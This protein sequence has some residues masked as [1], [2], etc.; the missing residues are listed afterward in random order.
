MRILGIS[1]GEVAGACLVRDGA[2]VSAVSEERF[3]R[4]KNLSCWPEQ[5]ISFVLG[6]DGAGLDS[7]DLIA[8]GYGGGFDRDKHLVLY[9]ERFIEESHSSPQRLHTLFERLGA[10]M[11][12]DERRISEFERW[13]A[14]EG[15]RDRTI[16]IDHHEAHGIGAFECSGFDDALVVTCDGRGDYQS[17]TVSVVCE[18]GETVLQRETSADSLGFYYGRITGLLGFRP[19]DQEGK[20]TGLAAYGDPTRA[21]DLVTRMV[22]LNDGRVRGQF[23][24]FFQPYYHGYSDNL[25]R[26]ASNFAPEDLAAAAQVHLENILGSIVERW[27]HRSR[28]GYLCLAGGVFANVKLNQRLAALPGVNATYVLPPMGDVGLPLQA[29]A[30]AARRTRLPR[31][32]LENVFLGPDASSD[33]DELLKACV[34]A[35]YIVVCESL[36][37]RLVRL[38]E[39]GGVVG[40]YRGRMEFGPRALC[41]RSVICRSSDKSLTARLNERLER[42]DFMPFGPIVAEELASMA[43]LGWSPDDLPSRFMTMTYECSDTFKHASPSVVHVDGT[44]RPQVITDRGDPFIHRLLLM[45]HEATGELGLVN[46]S[47][48]V[49][50]EPIVC[51]WKDAFQGLATSRIDALLVGNDALVI[52]DGIPRVGGY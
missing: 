22:R 36:H 47:F 13:I 3:A 31:V 33:S 2:V 45:W 34:A 37:L 10:E 52:A 11:R 21:M 5:S 28:S 9:L 48:N 1:N 17:L 44:A 40:T 29:A 43:F 42:S 19:N 18:S 6:S 41:N 7:V 38:L 35:G 15:L 16:R 8:Y 50:E 4:A 32:R 23:G 49:H 14:R 20:V 39:S 27:I 24:D 46:T 25:V 51:S 12:N 30:V 26:A